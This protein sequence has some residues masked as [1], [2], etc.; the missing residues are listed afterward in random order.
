MFNEQ[1]KRVA[2]M[3]HNFRTAKRSKIIQQCSGPS[4][5][6]RRSFWSHISANKKQSTNIS[7]VIDS[8]SGVVRCDPEDI[9]V[10]TEKYLMNI[11]QGSLEEIPS[12]PVVNCPHADH[13]YMEIRPSVPGAMPDHS[14]SVDPSPSLPSLDSGGSLE[15]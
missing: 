10:E 4:A 3:L 12:T 2:D 5:K 1:H 15:L 14:Y 13:T 6:A 11:Y 9:K 7:A 8:T